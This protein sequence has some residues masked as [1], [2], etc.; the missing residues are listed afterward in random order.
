MYQLLALLSGIILAI[1]ISVNGGLS[2]QYGIFLATV[3]VHVIGSIF[4][5]ILCHKKSENLQ[6]FKY[7]PLWMYLG[8]AI[9][10]LTTLFH[11]LAFTKISVTSIIALSLFGQTITSLI[12]DKFGIFGMQKRVF[13]RTSLGDFFFQFLEY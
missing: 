9:G 4:A 11:N 8:G 13:E 7:K 3:I 1:M 2:E 6:L 10:V 5:L 12:V